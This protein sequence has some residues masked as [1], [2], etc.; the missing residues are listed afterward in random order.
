MEGG[1][2]KTFGS[3]QSYNS[4]LIRNTNGEVG[5]KRVRFRFTK[6]KWN[7]RALADITKV[8][9]EEFPD[10]EVLIVRAGQNIPILDFNIYTEDVSEE[11][12]KEVEKKIL[13]VM[14][15]HDISHIV[16]RG[17]KVFDVENQ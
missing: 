8:F 11:K 17:V 16:L 10:S 4:F 12:L 9:A 13:E 7:T 1:L 14:T 5:M 6:A 2:F 3:T 15:E